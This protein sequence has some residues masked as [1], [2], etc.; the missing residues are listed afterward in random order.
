[1]FRNR[2][3]T[4]GVFKLIYILDYLENKAFS[5]KFIQKVVVLNDAAIL[6]YD[7]G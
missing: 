7:L 2:L 4:Q 6:E 1:L 3:C 5:E